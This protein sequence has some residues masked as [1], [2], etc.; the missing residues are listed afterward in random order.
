MSPEQVRGKTAGPRS[1]I[2]SFGLILYELLAGKRAFHG[3]TSVEIMTA[4]LKQD[5]PDLPDTVPASLRAIVMHCLEKDPAN[6][7][8]SAKD[9][10]FALAHSSGSSAKLPAHAAPWRKRWIWAAPVLAALAAAALGGHF[11]WRAS[12]P[13]QWSGAMLGGPEIAIQPRISPG[14][15]LLAFE[16][17]DRGLTQVAVMKPET[18]NWSLLTHSRDHGLVWT[19]SWSA[20]GSAI[21]YD[22]MADVFQGVYSVPVLGGDE[23]LVLADAGMPVGLPDGSL[24]LVRRNEQRQQQYYRYWPESGQLKALPIVAGWP[25]GS[26][27]YGDDRMIAG[28]NQAMVLGREIGKEPYRLFTVDLVSDAVRSL[29]IPEVERFPT[30]GVSGDGQSILATGRGHG[31]NPILTIPP[32]GGPIRILFTAT[33]DVWS[34]EGGPAGSIFADLGERPGEV[35]RISEAGGAPERIA[36]FRELVPTDL[37]LVLPDGRSVVAAVVNGHDRLMAVR[38]GSE[39]VP[40][41]STGEETSTPFC[42]AGPGKIAFALG[43]PPHTTIAIAEIQNGRIVQKFSPGKGDI[44]SLAASADGTTF[45][46]ASAGAVWAISLSGGE[47]HRIAAGDSAVIEPSGKALIVQRAE[48][49]RIHLFRVPLGG[50][51]EKEI[52]L[53]PSF[54]L[55]GWPLSP[56]ALDSK[57]RLLI[58]LALRDSW[59]NPLAIVDT[60]TGRLTRIPGD[61]SSDYHTAAWTPDGHIVTIQLGL[62][63]ALWKFAPHPK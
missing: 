45:Y 30:L 34:L 59:F 17:M 48:S 9:L 31:L 56:G 63:A 62:R 3:E 61:D 32:G 50:G 35:I 42:L 38:R 13:P 8:Q 10:G 53:D 39:A 12:E 4:I 47:P 60:A 36:D 15:Q 55:V 1:D 21:Y 24:L 19:L 54:I 29:N 51:A 28:K 25:M 57:G 5:P 37:I 43:P 22:R 16:A 6:R 26:L 33:S 40:L 44:D 23:H 41:I 49:G 7:F 2:F 52:S 11:L 18:G 27:H 58:T 14:G 20:D 46:F